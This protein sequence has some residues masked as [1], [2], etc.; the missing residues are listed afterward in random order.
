MRFI[1][2]YAL[3]TFNCMG[4]FELKGR[5]FNTTFE[6]DKL[7]HIEHIYNNEYV[8]KKITFLKNKSI[9][10]NYY[11][12][13]SISSIENLHINIGRKSTKEI[14]IYQK[15]L[16]FSKHSFE[17][18]LDLIFGYSIGENQSQVDEARQS[19][20][21]SCS[22]NN[23]ESQIIELERIIEGT[24]GPNG[25][26]IINN[27]PNEGE[28]KENI[29]KSLLC[30]KSKAS[31]SPNSISSILL[32][33]LQL[34]SLASPNGFN[35]NCFYEDSNVGGFATFPSVKGYPSVNLNMFPHEG[36]SPSHQS[37]RVI[38]HEI[39][40]SCNEPHSWENPKEIDIVDVCALCC[41]EDETTEEIQKACD[42]CQSPPPLDDREKLINYHLRI[43]SLK[44]SYQNILEAYKAQLLA[45][46][47]T[48]GI[49]AMVEMV[50]PTGDTPRD[51]ILKDLVKYGDADILFLLE[52]RISE[53]MVTMNCGLDYFDTNQSDECT[54]M[55]R[56]KRILVINFCK[57]DNLLRNLLGIAEIKTLCAA[58]DDENNLLSDSRVFEGIIN[59]KE[60]FSS[61]KMLEKISQVDEICREQYEIARQEVKRIED[62]MSNIDVNF[63]RLHH[64]FVAPFD[65]NEDEDD[66]WVDETSTTKDE[67]S[68]AVDIQSTPK[69]LE[70]AEELIREVYQLSRKKNKVSNAI[71]LHIQS[72]QT[73][74]K[75]LIIG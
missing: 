31:E 8:S 9:T 42:L 15:G 60:D 17:I 28:I 30:L 73:K 4:A 49:D 55:H 2:L 36:A 24:S 56:Q 26:F 58:P 51:G 66:L 48:S 54:K 59:T 50:F 19:L 10:T 22:L 6:K 34:T 27:C 1:L 62:Q 67:A 53:K 5:N 20:G 32:E 57:R 61:N 46:D 52:K 40:H 16:P 3:V 72:L 71:C 12:P 33:K 18:N 23:D 13:K 43:A 39:F 44:P 74:I 69:Q 25:L 64:R 11:S 45:P 38:A 70:Q 14:I 7:K 29:K 35:I 47:Q 63:I 65:F 68:K 37:R 21:L 75:D 41:S